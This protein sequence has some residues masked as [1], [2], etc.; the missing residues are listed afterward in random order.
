[1]IAFIIAAIGAILVFY[2]I[3]LAFGI[4]SGVVGSVFLNENTRYIA[5]GL[6]IFAVIG[7]WRGISSRDQQADQQRQNNV[8]Q[9]R[10]CVSRANTTA[11]LYQSRYPAGQLE[12]AR[13]KAVGQCELNYPVY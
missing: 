2:A 3:V 12:T 10:E 4:T 13:Q 5:I 6:T 11:R 7:I 9:Q 1:M 8:A